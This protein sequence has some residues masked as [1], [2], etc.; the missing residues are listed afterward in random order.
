MR[1]EYFYA[2][3][4]H[5]AVI[6]NSFSESADNIQPE[7][8]YCQ[9]A[10]ETGEFTSAMCVE[11]NNLGGLCQ[12]QPNDTPQPDGNQFYMQFDSYEAYAEYFGRYLRYY[13]E[14]GI[15]AAGTLE[16][17]VRALKDGQYFGDDVENYLARTGEI[18]AECFA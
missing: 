7:W 8:I 17:Y 9:W 4:K 13:A 14:N 15:Y 12:T 1:N 18:Y 3:A 2:L 10:H 11:Y 5:S 16:D 6:A